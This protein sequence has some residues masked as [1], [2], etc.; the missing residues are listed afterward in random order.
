MRRAV[1]EKVLPAGKV[2]PAQRHQ[3]FKTIA[4]ET[5][6]TGVEGVRLDTPRT[7]D[8][9]EQSPSS[10]LHSCWPGRLRAACLESGRLSLTGSLS[11]GSVVSPLIHE[12]EYRPPAE[13]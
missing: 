3:Q 4:Q 2:S 1:V 13:Q 5:T 10:P 8:Q 6:L 11:L 9:E 12:Q 7:R